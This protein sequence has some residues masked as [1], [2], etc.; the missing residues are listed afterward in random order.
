MFI[1]FCPL[2]VVWTLERLGSNG[3]QHH[4]NY[5]KSAW[6][7]PN[8]RTMV[9]ATIPPNFIFST[10]TSTVQ[11]QPIFI[12]ILFATL[13]R[14]KNASFCTRN[15][16]HLF[17]SKKVSMNEL[18]LSVLREK[19]RRKFTYLKKILRRFSSDKEWFFREIKKSETES[20]KNNQ[21]R[22]WTSFWPAWIGSSG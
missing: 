13:N 1:P 15:A 18:Y 21:I 20:D 6:G 2:E 14:D 10:S 17:R 16:A 5:G 11:S 8:A 3:H 22:K 9:S 7:H 12:F 19:K 4:H